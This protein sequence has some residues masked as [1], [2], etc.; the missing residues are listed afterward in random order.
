MNPETARNPIPSAPPASSGSAAPAAVTPP[1]PAQSPVVDLDLD[2]DVDVAER[3]ESAAR[4]I[5]HDLN[6][7]LGIIGGRAELVLMYLEQGRIDGARKGV[8]VV[9][10]QVERMKELTDSIRELRTRD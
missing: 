7:C 5:G 9:L 4:D 8:E 10:G 1:A 6:N 2:L 3:M